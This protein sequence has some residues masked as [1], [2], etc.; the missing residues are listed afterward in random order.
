MTN[1]RQ[2]PTTSE[3]KFGKALEDYINSLIRQRRYVVPIFTADPPETDPTNLWLRYDGRLRGRVPNGSGYTYYDY[4]MRSDISSPP[5]VPAYPAAPTPP[6]PPQS[7][8]KTWTANWS[9]TYKGDGN[10]RPDTDGDIY[11]IFGTDGAWGNQKALVGF[12]YADMVSTL[13]GSTL[14]SISLTMTPVS[15]YYASGTQVALGMH[16]QAGWVASYDASTTILRY[17]DQETITPGQTATYTLPLA[18]AQ[19]LRA[20]TAKGLVFE[21]PNSSPGFLGA[22]A[23]VGSPYTPPQLTIT[24]AK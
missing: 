23:S 11:A 24:Y 18:F 16:N 9:Q 8:T 12:D 4:P 22:I 3:G 14:L 20:G 5:A 10:Y 15:T 7:M 1:K 21:A 19:Q 6:T 2:V 17:G 13:T